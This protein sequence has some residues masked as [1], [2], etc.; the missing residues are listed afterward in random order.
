MIIK[1]Q[2]LMFAGNIERS[3]YMKNGGY[4]DSPSIFPLLAMEQDNHAQNQI[5]L[6][7]LLDQYGWPTASSVTEHAAACAALIVNHATYEIRKKYFP[8]LE[9]AFKAGEAQPLRYA[10]MRDRLLV[11]EG[12]EQLHGTQ[13]RFSKGKRVP[14]PIQSPQ[15]VDK[16]RAEIGLGPLKEYLKE[17]FDID[18]NVEQKN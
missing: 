13:W 11:E 3:K 5:K 8:M 18:W 10:K 12:K 15:L 7:Q 16:R 2:G 17:R 14:H 1:D 4:F 9:K 6:F